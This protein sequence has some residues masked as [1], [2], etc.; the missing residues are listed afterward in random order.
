MFDLSFM[1]WTNMNQKNS[2]H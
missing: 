2:Q 1:Y